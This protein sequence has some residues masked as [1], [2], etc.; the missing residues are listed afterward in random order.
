MPAFY[1][2]R[3]QQP[4]TPPEYNTG[5]QNNGCGNM[6][7]QQQQHQAYGMPQALGRSEEMSYDYSGRY[8]HQ[9]TVTHAPSHQQQ[10]SY[11]STAMS[12]PAVNRFIEPISLPL[13]PV[14]SFDQP[15]IS[16]PEPPQYQRSLEY[17]PHAHYEQHHQQEQQQQ[18][19]KDEKPVGGVSARLD[20]EMECM[21]DFVSDMAQQLYDFFSSRASPADIDTIRSVQQ[22]NPSHSGFRS[23]VHSV[24]CATRLPAATIV[25]SLHYLQGRMTMLQERRELPE[26]GQIYRVL[27]VALILGSKFLDDNTFINR[28]WAEVSCIDINI[29]N[30]MEKAWLEDIDFRLHHDPIEAKGFQTWLAYWKEY[31]KSKSGASVRGPRIDPIDTNV[32]RQAHVHKTFTPQSTQSAFPPPSAQDYHSARAQQAQYTPAWTPYD[33]WLVPRSGMETS[34]ASAPHTGPTTPEYYGGP[35]TWAPL[36]T[37]AYSYQR[38]Y[39][40]SALSQPQSQHHVQPLPQTQNYQTYNHHQY[41]QHGWNGHSVHCHCG[42]CRSGN[43]W[44]MNTGFGPQVAVA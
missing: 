9:Q 6:H 38:R 8:T 33:P 11:P 7:F 43:T 28:S 21:A 13:P 17:R 3:H 31:E 36:D 20:Y 19:A 42:Q 34:P 24:L 30:S 2:T 15:V 5:Y 12:M 18:K 32:P 29:L 35:G 26:E 25:L 22:G 4:L 39:G 1:Q 41:Q 23:W 10:P 16:V 27:T 44:Y 14:R 40:F 37:G